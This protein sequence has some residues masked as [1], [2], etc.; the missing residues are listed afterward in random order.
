MSFSKRRRRPGRAGPVTL[1]AVT[2]VLTVTGVA[3]PVQAAGTPVPGGDAGT[4]GT[5]TP[6]L[7]DGLFDAVDASV[8]AATAARDHL[9]GHKDRY[10]IPSPDR[11]LV[12]GGVTEDPD[13]TE[14]VRL[15][16]KYQG[17]PVLGAQ[18]VVRMTHEN[19]RRT[20]TGTSGSFF[21][22]LEVDTAGATLPAATAVDAAVR[23]VRA[24]LARGG[25][26]PEH[27]ESAKDNLTGTDRGLTVLPAGKG[28]LAR[29][30]TVRGTDPATGNPV[31]QE[32][33]VDAA[34]GTT[35]FEAGGLPTFTAPRQAG[36]PHDV[37][38]G[39]GT[40]GK[41]GGSAPGSSG[42]TGSGTLQNGTS[43]S[44]NLTKDDAT[45]GYLLRDTARMAGT[46][47]HNAIQTWDAS[48]VWYQ[49]VSGQWPD[50][51]VPYTSPTPQ[52]GAAL[53]ESGAVDAHWAAGQV[54]DYYRDTFH[55]NSLDGQGMAINSLVGVTDY[56][57][58]YVNA[59][60]DH[61]KMVY[62]TGSPEYRS[63]ASDLDVVGHEMTHGVVEHTADLVYSGQSGAM[64]EAMADYF[65]N[66]I[67][68]TAGHT[69]MT[70][71]D[72]GLIGGDLCR[73]LP[74]RQCAFRDLN[75]GATTAH[76]AGLPLGSAGDN[77]GVHMNSTI[78]SGALWDIRE[79]LGGTLADKI[80]YRALTRYLTPLDG[81]DEGRDAV[82]AA[83]RSLGVHGG[84]LDTV[85]KAFAAHGITP[86]WE[87]N[88][89]LD[90][91]VLLGR[92]GTMPQYVGT[93]NVPSAGG[94]WW[95]VPK[96]S[97]DGVD[98]YSVWTGRTD[99]RGKP[100]QV[101]PDDG[102]SHMSP[103]TDGRRVVWVAVGDVPGSQWDHTYAIM[104]AP[105]HGGHAKTLFTLPAGVTTVSGVG[106]DGDTVAW[107]YRNPETGRLQVY[108]LKGD[109]TTP[110]PV[111]IG[112]TGNQASQ[113]AVKNG[114]IAFI[115]DGLFDD[116]YGVRVEVYDTADGST[117]VLGPPAT[118]EW[119][120]A[121]VM[122]SSDV[123]WLIDTDYTDQDQTTL[124][125]AHLD[126]SGTPQVTDVIP[127]KSEH[128]VPAYGLAAT[129]DAV[130]LAVYP[131]WGSVFEDPNDSLAKLYQYTP[132]GTPLGRVS[133]GVG[134]QAYPAAGTG[135]EVLWI[136]TTTTDGN[137]VTRDH[138]AGSCD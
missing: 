138:P 113:P 82:V 54:Y 47:Q 19:G 8:P 124:R 121:P 120:S 31:V 126:G 52:L 40:T 93:G 100:H 130:T 87:K 30:V 131:P 111:P 58:P 136:D 4:P 62:G 128:A 110:Q 18:Y 20:V 1:L 33:Y 94:G 127:E 28:V 16:Q 39:R 44:L 36:T 51:V 86:G 53:T 14:T 99:G 75:D 68:V 2:A 103:V 90:S 17:V 89:G 49:D 96:S 98:P 137:L 101:S 34:T 57:S 78:F 112:R 80:V 132:D 115:E 81:F 83:A 108:Y 29:H 97:P 5:E 64:N 116:E 85:K 104:A 25:Y 79:A 74:P 23:S 102:R 45:G 123:Y 9:A 50:T 133:C 56:G 107:S 91:D 21:T 24:S 118:P 73:N 65:G 13:G 38:T 22:G 70:D 32:L 109:A 72:A 7:V 41:P 12:T 77:G 129:D 11:D 117:T 135:S 66:A 55:R 69:P 27:S 71:P 3:S 10:R 122:T 15:D 60:W 84:G 95:A 76:F 67:D 114:R 6:A 63:L 134:D 42:V 26:R 61:T 35:L 88:L 59:F 125:R 46:P 43:V 119:I 105:V 37:G 92:L 48:S 106:V